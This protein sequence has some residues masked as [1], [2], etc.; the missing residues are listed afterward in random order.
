MAEMN[1]PDGVSRE[2]LAEALKAVRAAKA[3]RERSKGETIH[4]RGEGGQIIEM[5]LPLPEPIADR[6]AKGHLRRVEPDGSPYGGRPAPETGTALTDGVPPRPGKTA[7]KGEWVAW[8]VRVHG[9]EPDNAEAMTKADLM[10]LPDQPA[11]PEDTSADS[12]L[13]AGRTPQ[14]AESDPKSEWIAYAVS[15]GHMSAEDAANLTKDDL[16]DLTT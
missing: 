1:I 2:E 8:A 5:S 4:V 6:L 14:P 12:A 7:V 10:D 16:I 13:T 3:R 9:L 15:Q 11:P